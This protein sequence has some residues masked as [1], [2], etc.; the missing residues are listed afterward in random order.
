MTPETPQ[1]TPPDPIATAEMDITALQPWQQSVIT[2]QLAD[3]TAVP[4]ALINR[5]PQG[6]LPRGANG[7]TIKTF[8]AQPEIVELL[9][10]HGEA[11]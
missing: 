3:P 9:A 7:A 1:N 11:A 2:L 5:I 10:Q 4:A 6:E 8:L